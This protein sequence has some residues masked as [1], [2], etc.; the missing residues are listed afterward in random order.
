MSIVESNTTASGSAV[1]DIVAQI[2]NALEN[3]K[4]LIDEEVSNYPRP[5]TACDVQFEHALDEQA[6]IRRELTRAE[7]LL[8]EARRPGDFARA[9]N[10]FVAESAFITAGTEQ[11]IKSSLAAI[12]SKPAL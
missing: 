10:E 1:Q 6:K 7:A 9:V 4:K 5:I 12:L 11:Q 8:D 3:R 2:E